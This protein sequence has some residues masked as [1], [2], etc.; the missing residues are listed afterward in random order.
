[1][2]T[3]GLPPEVAHAVTVASQLRQAARELGLWLKECGH[4]SVVDMSEPVRDDGAPSG[5]AGSPDHTHPFQ[6]ELSRMEGR[7]AIEQAAQLIGK[8]DRDRFQPPAATDRAAGI[9][10]VSDPDIEERIL[11]FNALKKRTAKAIAGISDR[12]KKRDKWIAVTSLKTLHL[13]EAYRSVVVLPRNTVKVAFGWTPH[14]NVVDKVTV[15]EARERWNIARGSQ[16]DAAFGLLGS[17]D[18][19]AHVRPMPPAP[20]ANVRLDDG[21]QLPRKTASMPFVMFGHSPPVI[22][23]LDDPEDVMNRPKRTARRDRKLMDT[24]LIPEIGLFAYRQNTPDLT[25]A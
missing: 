11:A 21:T 25:S 12:R 15:A 17:Q 7:E 10:M 22:R 9:V 6:R 14:S 3:N 24:P 13:I 2:S 23:R 4:F 20:I 5:G 19:I 8:I 16:W 18:E 1:M